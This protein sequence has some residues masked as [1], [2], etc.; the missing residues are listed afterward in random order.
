MCLN[1]ERLKRHR[2]HEPA[3]GLEFHFLEG[4]SVVQVADGLLEGGQTA[5]EF[6]FG[7]LAAGVPLREQAR[8]ITTEQRSIDEVEHRASAQTPL[9]EETMSNGSCAAVCD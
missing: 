6:V 5:A 3:D 7:D 8:A 1:S 4:N 9:C 2:E